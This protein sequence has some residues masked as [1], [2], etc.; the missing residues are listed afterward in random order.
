MYESLMGLAH[1]SS[2]E[3]SH[4]KWNICDRTRGQGRCPLVGISTAL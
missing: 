3:F 1:V 4:F 2:T